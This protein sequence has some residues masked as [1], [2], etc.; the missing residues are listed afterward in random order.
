MCGEQADSAGGL[1]GA[2]WSGGATEEEEDRRGAGGEEG[3][4]GPGMAIHTETCHW[5]G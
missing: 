5:S 2:M 4:V 3:G 1:E